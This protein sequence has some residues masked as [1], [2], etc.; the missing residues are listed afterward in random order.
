MSE[1]LLNLL[2]ENRQDVMLATIIHTSSIFEHAGI[3]VIVFRRDNDERIRAADFV[4]EFLEAGRGIVAAM[5]AFFHDRKVVFQQ[6]EQF[7]GNTVPLLQSRQNKSRDL[8]AL[9]VPARAADNDWNVIHG[10]SITLFTTHR[11]CREA[12]HNGKP[13]LTNSCPNPGLHIQNHGS[14]T[15]ALN[16]ALSRMGKGWSV[17]QAYVTKGQA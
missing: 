10:C 2:A 5:Q 14:F 3:A 4:T 13:R 17:C 11:F 1:K 12:V 9:A 7:R 16:G 15:A 8:D 6:V